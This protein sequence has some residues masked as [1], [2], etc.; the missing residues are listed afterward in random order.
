MDTYISKDSK[1]GVQG[2][3]YSRLGNVSDSGDGEK[4]INLT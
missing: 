2:R 1:A 3:D 4:V